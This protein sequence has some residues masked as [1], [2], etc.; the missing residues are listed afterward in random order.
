MQRGETSSLPAGASS[1]VSLLW[2]H[3]GDEVL[4]L[5]A[6]N[7][8][9]ENLVVADFDVGDLDLGLVWDEVHLSFSLL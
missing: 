8:V 6:L 9:L 5:E 2:L 3:G 7:E 1:V 4:H